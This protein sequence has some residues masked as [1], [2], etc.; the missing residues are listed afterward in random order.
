M[1]SKIIS[2][3]DKSK[4]ENQDK[5][6]IPIS[7]IEKKE[8]Q[9]YQKLKESELRYRRLFETA[10]DG[11]L[12]LD[13]ETGEILDANPFI[14]KTID[15][16][17]IE[18]IGKRL[19]EIGLFS[20]KEESEL[21]FIELKTN[22][23]IR[24]EDMPIQR[25]DGKVTEVEFISNVYLESNKK[26]IQCNIRDITERIK[27]E[28]ALLKSEQDLKK[29][30]TEYANLN[31]E[32]SALNEELKESIARMQHINNHLI[33]AKDKAEESDKLKSSFLANMSHEIRTPMNAIIGFSEFLL[34]PGI[35]QKNTDRYVQIINA[36]SQQ[37]LSIISD[38]MDISKIEA[39][40]FSVDLKPVNIDDL[41]SELFITYKKL[42]DFKNVSLIYSTENSN[43]PI[44]VNTDGGRIRQIICNLLNNAI[45]FTREGEIKFG[46]RLQENFL[47]FFVTDSGIGIAPENLA[48]I[49]QRFMQVEASNTQ[50]NEGNGLGL[51]ISKALVEKLGGSIS[52]ISE[53]GVGSSFTFTIPNKSVN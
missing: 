43:E 49:F 26:V 48:L 12:I 11:I 29:Q 37:L 40:K 45:K 27:A 50:L 9:L 36:S 41:M 22:G 44:Q 30:N 4:K 28:F 34:E 19:W 25:R 21:A 42:I 46:Y 35:S 53:P 2:I 31:K 1:D 6:R 24:F 18:I 20:N 13:F 15:F 39:G 16:P 7:I 5:I 51:T 52:V 17:L 3:T 32:Y 10:K 23:Y 8:V 14:V 47:E 33:I 38:V